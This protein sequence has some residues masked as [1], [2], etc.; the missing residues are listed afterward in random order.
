MP[1]RKRHG[2]SVR[3]ELR[4]RIQLI[5][6]LGNRTPEWSAAETPQPVQSSVEE[7]DLTTIAV[8]AHLNPCDQRGVGRNREGTQRYAQVDPPQY[9]SILASEVDPIRFRVGGNRPFLA[10][11]DSERQDL[12]PYDDPRKGRLH[13]LRCHGCRP[14]RNAGKPNPTFGSAYSFVIKALGWMAS[15]LSSSDPALTN[16]SEIFSSIKS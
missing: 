9:R 8:P 5:V 16:R 15:F 3:R 2:L 12:Y 13:T 7:V 10:G 11:Y 4:I 14:A 6:A 1:D